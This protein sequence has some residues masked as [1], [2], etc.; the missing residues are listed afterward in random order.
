MKARCSAAVL[1]GSYMRMKTF[2][3]L[4]LLAGTLSGCDAAGY[5]LYVFAPNKR[6]Q[7]V[8]AEFGGL[9]GRSVAIVIYADA[10]VQ[11]EYPWVRHELA[12]TIASQLKQH[13]KGVEVVDPLRVIAYQ[14]ENIDWNA[15]G[16][17]ELGRTL[18][19]DH[20]LSVVLIEYSTR[21]RG[22]LNIYRGRITAQVRVYQTSLPERDS[23]VW[24]GED[25]RVLYPPDVPMGE[26][27]EDDDKIRHRTNIVFARTLVR[28]FYK[29]EVPKGAER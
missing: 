7:T 4:L 18:G 28:K 3:V 1:K 14:D 29:H 27:G 11:Y 17:T 24:P 22:S 20:V 8:E 23:C 9:A 21:D 15:L 10:A 5:L 19:A 6:T 16:K 13:V 2:I 26:V 25:I 12:A